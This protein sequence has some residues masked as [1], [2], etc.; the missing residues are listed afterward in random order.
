MSRVLRDY[1]EGLADM[2]QEG[3]RGPAGRE[4]R[5]CRSRECAAHTAE[6]D[7]CRA[8]RRARA[9][10]VLDRTSVT[11]MIN[12]ILASTGSSTGMRQQ[13]CELATLANI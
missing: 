3:A 4:P 5:L 8:E 10:H 9:K 11:T 2:S 6:R 13:Q 12:S 1:W 7:S